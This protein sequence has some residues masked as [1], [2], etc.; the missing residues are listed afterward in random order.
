MW[1]QV[2]A[3]NKE[4]FEWVKER[5]IAELEGE[6]A[7]AEMITHLDSIVLP[8]TAPIETPETK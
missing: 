3:Q 4:K 8:T 2:K 6:V 7:P 1:F 5:I